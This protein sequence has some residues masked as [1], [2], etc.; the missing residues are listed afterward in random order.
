MEIYGKD[1]ATQR[2]YIEKLDREHNLFLVATVSEQVV[3]ILALIDTLLCGAAEPS[4]AVGVHLVRDWRGRG[5]GSAMLRYGMR[6]AKEHGYQRLEADIFTTN[7]RSVHLFDK[8]GFR[9]E[10]CRRRSVQVWAHQ[11]N[12]VILARTLR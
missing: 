4:L 1:A 3:G 11:I 7:K 9:E 8:A 6:W 2:A 5:I 10:T 12:E